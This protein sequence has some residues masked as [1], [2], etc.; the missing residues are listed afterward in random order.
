MTP[1][2]GPA[3]PP[4]SGPRPPLE[5]RRC[6]RGSAWAGVS[7]PG[8]DPH[9]SPSCGDPKPQGL[10]EDSWVQRPSRGTPAQEDASSLQGRSWKESQSTVPAV[11]SFRGS[12]SSILRR[13]SLRGGGEDWL[14]ALPEPGRPR[15]LIKPADWRWTVGGGQAE[16]SGAGLKVRMATRANSPQKGRRHR[17][18]QQ[19]AATQTPPHPGL[20]F[21]QAAV[22]PL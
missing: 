17:P 1:A 9:S 22:R 7:L 18:Q 8:K 14:R 5:L 19:K 13:D 3:E 21:P 2:H 4:Q 11:S 20:L 15:A 6:Q 12:E 10:L 16:S